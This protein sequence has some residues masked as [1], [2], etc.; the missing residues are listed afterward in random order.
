MACS[1][2][3]EVGPP[4]NI[5][6]SET[7]FDDAATV[8]STLTN[9]Y[10]KIRE[11]GLLSGNFGMTTALGIYSDEL[12]YYGFDTDH[13]ELYNHSVLPSNG[14][15]L[16]WWGH[17]YNLIY[18]ANDIIS[19]VEGSDGLSEEETARFMGQALFVRAYVHSLLASL[20]GDVPYIRTT[21]YLRNNSVSRLPVGEVYAHIIDDLKKAMELLEGTG[22]ISTDR[23]LPDAY[24][25]KALLARMYLYTGNWDLAESMATELID[26]FALEP[27]LGDVFLKGSTG[28]IWQLRPGENPRNTQEANQ[29]IIEFIPGQTYALA[30]ALLASFEAGDL[31][32]DQWV[33]SISDAGNTV[34]LHFAHK[35]KATFRET[36]SLEH[37]ILFRLAEQYLIRAEARAHLGKLAGARQDLNKIRNRAG[38]SDT[39]ANTLSDLLSAILQ[40]RRVELFA[41]L[42]HRWFDLKRTGRAGEVLGALK[43]NW[44]ATDVL[45]PIPEAELEV[46]PNLLPQNPGY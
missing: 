1:D 33:G 10:H 27:E 6:V 9:M 5:L 23:V 8:E 40:E 35:Y 15:I 39:G 38:L 37:S 11:Q 14:T 22:E 45:L 21:D 44:R 36:E 25:I 46:N 7:V 19:G 30:E 28:T 2:F 29:L 31:R 17:A 26:S 42:G 18:S 3:V 34:T 16:A 20:F 12:D 13:L 32:K 43:P 24:V 41:E 4:K